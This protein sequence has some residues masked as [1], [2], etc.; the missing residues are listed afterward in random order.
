MSWFSDVVNVLRVARI[1]IGLAEEVRKPIQELI[2]SHARDEKAARSGIAAGEAADNS[3]KSAHRPWNETSE[4]RR[5][6]ST[7]SNPGE[8][9]FYWDKPVRLKSLLFTRPDVAWGG[10]KSMKINGGTELLRTFLV[11]DGTRVIAWPN[12]WAEGVGVTKVDV[13]VVGP[14]ETRVRVEVFP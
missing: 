7:Y 14:G 8:V 3:A 11:I 2:E 10:V 5:T 12:E 9:S 6:V 1:L 13:V 4:L